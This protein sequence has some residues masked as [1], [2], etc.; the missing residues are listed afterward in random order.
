MLNQQISDV[1]AHKHL[2]LILSK[3]CSWHEHIRY[4]TEKAST[5]ICI[6]CKLKYEL[7]HKSLETIYIALIRPLLEYGDIIWDDCS[8]N[9]ETELDKIQNEAAR[10]ATGATKLVSINALYSEIRWDKLE[11][12]RKNHRLTLFYKVKH[13][14]NPMYLNSLV[15]ESVGN[16][17]QYNLHNSNNLQSINTRTTQYHQSCLPTAFREWNK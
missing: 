7:D 9:Q 5:R 8:Q 3:Y 2:G 1:N 11:Q 14:L 6:L 17:S 13:N 10:I 15:P 12:R 4:I 16:V